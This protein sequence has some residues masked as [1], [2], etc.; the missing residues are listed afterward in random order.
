M[1]R[2]FLRHL[3]DRANRPDHGNQSASKRIADQSRCLTKLVNT[4]ELT[5]CGFCR[6]EG[7]FAE[8]DSACPAVHF[9]RT[10]TRSLASCSSHRNPNCRRRSTCR[11]WI[12]P[13]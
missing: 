9:K 4:G 13:R 10:P 12:R 5:P 1:A 8:P 3:D 11:P 2:E 6:I 7:S